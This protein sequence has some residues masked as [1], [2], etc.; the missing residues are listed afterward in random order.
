MAEPQAEVDTD[1]LKPE[2]IE[3]IDKLEPESTD[4]DTG[5]KE[6][7]EKQPQGLE[8]TR[9]TKGSLPKGNNFGVRKRINK[10]KGEADGAKQREDEANSK[11]EL[12]RKKNE[13]LRLQIDQGTGNSKP[14]PDNYDGGSYDP[15]FEKD[16]ANFN[17][18]EE[19]SKQVAE[20]TKDIRERQENDKQASSLRRKQDTYY[21]QA[22]ELEVSD[23][24]KTETKALDTLGLE[25]TNAIINNFTKDSHYLVYYFGKNEQEA[26]NF[27]HLWDTDKIQAIAEIGGILAELKVSPKTATDTQPAPD[28]ELEGGSASKVEML[29]RKYD[30]LVEKKMKSPGD[31]SIYPKMIQLKKEMAKAG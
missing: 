26:D 11:F 14:N 5:E 18:K 22:D 19:V 31:A 13:I 24:G 1:D 2:E 30:K 6:E 16:T 29:Q 15:A 7:A 21:D 4:E 20:S 23:F 9:E 17:I 25:A 10:L 28:E 12:E 8:I 27:R 3:K